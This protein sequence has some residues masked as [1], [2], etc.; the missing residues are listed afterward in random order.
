[1]MFER[2]AAQARRVVADNGL[3]A[4]VVV[5]ADED[6]HDYG[7]WKIGRASCRERV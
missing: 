6:S 4:H 7:V 3:D 5:D 1:M 2:W